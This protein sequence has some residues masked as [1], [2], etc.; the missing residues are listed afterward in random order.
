MSIDRSKLLLDRPAPYVARLLIN[1]PDKRNAIDYDVR[2]LF[3]EALTELRGDTGTRALVIGG[4]GGH[5]S[6][7]G[8]LPSMIGLSEAEARARLSHIG[9]LCKLLAAFERPVVTAMEGASAGACVGLALLGDEIVV[10]EN[11]RI[12]LPFM[13]LG[14]VPD[15]GSLLTLPRRI[16]LAQTRRLACSGDIID[17]AQAL[18][19][20]IADQLAADGAVMEAAVARAGALAKLPQ[21]AFALL[22]Q[23]LN[24]PSASLDQELQRE[25]DDQ[26]R[27]LGSADFR[28][29]FAAFMEK[30]RADFVGDGGSGEQP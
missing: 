6:A 26:A 2:Q 22:K 11:V 1:R 25:E 24:H 15:W 21:Q 10:G 27:L 14:L 18:Q 29:G 30:R 12:T 4:V 28:E 20:G 13:K 16:G 17:G 9:S 23:R 8:D 5:F 7:G 19:I 3:I